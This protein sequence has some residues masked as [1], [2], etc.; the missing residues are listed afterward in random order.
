[1][2]ETDRAYIAGLIDGEGTITLVRN[3]SKYRSPSVSIA[4][5]S[6]EL[7]EYTQAATKNIKSTIISKKVYKEHHKPS[8]ALNYRHNAALDLLT[9]IYPYLKEKSKVYRA[10]ILLNE[11]KAVTN[12]GGHYTED[13]LKTKLDFEYRFFHPDLNHINKLT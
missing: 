3:H 5:T 9:E 2:N 13:K 10:Q 1:M 6:I 11:Y 8:Y 7:L 12:R 4:S